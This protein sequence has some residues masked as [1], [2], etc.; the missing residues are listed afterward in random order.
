MDGMEQSVLSVAIA[1][2]PVGV[3]CGS[4]LPIE[5]H[6]KKAAKMMDGTNTSPVFNSI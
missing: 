1:L 6:F 3:V 4:D 2:V 5:I